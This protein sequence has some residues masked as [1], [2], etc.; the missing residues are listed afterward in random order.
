[1][2][3]IANVPEAQVGLLRSGT[4]AEVRAAALGQDAIT[5]RV[6][7]IDPVLNEETRTARVR[8]E[9][10][11]SGERLKVGMFTEVGF[12]TGT[13]EGTGEELVV[14]SEAVQRVGARTVVFIPKDAPG[15]FE[16]RDVDV[17]GETEGYR[18]ITNGLSLGERVVTKGSFSLKSQM[19][20]GQF[21]EDVDDD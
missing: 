11:N 12:E 19:M 20:K 13:G 3:V 17:G 18:R 5:G 9:V 4:P 16:V 2:W 6:T 8:V 10:A 15:H 14:P 1:V 21:G 7:Y